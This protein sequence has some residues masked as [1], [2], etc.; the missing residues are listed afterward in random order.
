[1]HSISQVPEWNIAFNALL[2]P[3]VTELESNGP[4][5]FFLK[6]SGKRARLAVPETSE[7]DYHRGV[8]EGLA[9]LVQ[10]NLSTF[11]PRGFLFEGRLTFRAGDQQVVGRCTIVLPPATHHPQVTIAK[12]SNSLLSLE[13]IASRGTMS[14]EMLAFLQ[15]AVEAEL[16]IVLSGSTGAGKTTMLEA[17]TKFIPQDR[18]IGVAEDVPELVLSQPNVAYLHSVPLQPKMDPNSVATLAWVVQ[19]FQRMRTD[20]L[21]IGETRGREFADFLTAAN[22][23]MDGSMTTIHADEPLACL[24]K[25]T[26]FTSEARPSVPTRAINSDIANAVN[27][28]VQLVLLPNGQHRVSHI[29]EVVPSLGSGEDAKITTQPLYTLDRPSDTFSKSGNMSDALRHRCES[30]GI[31]LSPFLNSAREKPMPAHGSQ[32]GESIHQMPQATGPRRL[33][34]GPL[35]GVHIP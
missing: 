6:R 16:N 13:G 8:Q 10:S 23:G 18:R 25:M 22:S 35:G 31:D 33:P 2:E 7:G 21:I 5:Q 29:Q 3:D 27:L 14:S 15:M 17:M 24:R 28:I 11:D 30:R 19:Q 20:K 32:G 34:T 4:G 12:R 26:N 1:M 9:P